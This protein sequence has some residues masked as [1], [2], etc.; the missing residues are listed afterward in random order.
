M[1][2]SADTRVAKA[3]A[4]LEGTNAFPQSAALDSLGRVSMTVTEFE[5]LCLMLDAYIRIDPF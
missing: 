1:R 3:K 2:V 5:T 4:L